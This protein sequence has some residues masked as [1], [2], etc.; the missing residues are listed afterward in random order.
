MLYLQLRD[1]VASEADSFFRIKQG[2]LPQHTLYASITSKCYTSQLGGPHSIVYL[3]GCL[4]F[5]QSACQV[6]QVPVPSCH[7]PSSKLSDVPAVHVLLQ[8]TYAVVQ[9]VVVQCKQ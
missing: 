7:D 9:A 1:A 6:S 2:G 4:A 8:V 3:Q 5:L